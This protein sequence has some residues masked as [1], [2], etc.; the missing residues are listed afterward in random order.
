MGTCVN[1]S[2]GKAGW[3]KEN[4]KRKKN[5]ATRIFKNTA[6]SLKKKKRC[7]PLLMKDQCHRLIFTT[8]DSGN[9]INQVTNG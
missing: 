7:F 3:K 2:P 1:R 9:T 8:S 4:R 6:A 5:L